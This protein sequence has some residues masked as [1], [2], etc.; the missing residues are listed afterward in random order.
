MNTVIKGTK[1]IE[2][3]KTVRKSMERLTAECFSRHKQAFDDWREGEPVKAWFD[4]D[5]NIC[6]EY[7]SGNWWHYNATGEWW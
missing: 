3:Y 2:E 4:S 1:T 6:V 7:Q 5:G